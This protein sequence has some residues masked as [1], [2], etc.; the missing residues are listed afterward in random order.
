MFQRH[1]ADAGPFIDVA[2][3]ADEAGHGADVPARRTQAGTA[4]KSGSSCG[5]WGVGAAFGAPL[6]GAFYAFEI[7]IGNYPPAA[8]APVM[9]AALSAVFVSRALGVDLPADYAEQRLAF[10]DSLS[11]EM[12]SS[13]HHDLEHGNSLEVEWLSGGVVTL[14]KKAGVPTPCN[15]AVWDVLAL[16]AAGSKK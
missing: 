15:R 10:A 14:G 2:N 4:F 3:D 16:H 9:V 6:A 7:V 12:T 1:A 5:G 11:P 8:I 13:L